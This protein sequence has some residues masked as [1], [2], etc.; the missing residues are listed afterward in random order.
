MLSGDAW[1]DLDFISRERS[2]LLNQPLDA[3]YY[4]HSQVYKDH[5]NINAIVHTHSIKSAALSCL[6]NNSIQPVHQNSCRFLLNTLYEKTYDG[7]ATSQSDEAQRISNLLFQAANR[8]VLVLANHGILTFGKTLAVAF[9]HAYYFERAVEVQFLAF[10]AGPVKL[11]DKD[12]A[13]K[14]S[15][16]VLSDHNETIML[17][18][19]AGAK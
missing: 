19:L 4:L 5:E 3:A 16:Q 12:T 6:R 14:T 8:E 17:S 11:I 9:D 15:K 10:K 18:F 1:I 13:V 7:I 2:L